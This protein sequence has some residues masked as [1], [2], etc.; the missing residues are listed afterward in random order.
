MLQVSQNCLSLA[1]TWEYAVSLNQAEEAGVEFRVL[2][3]LEVI[4]PNAAPIDLPSVSQRRLVC[5]LLIRGTMVS[6]DNLAHHLEVSPGA[7]RTTVS[8]LRRLL[9]PATLVSAPPGYQL[10]AEALDAREFEDCLAGAAAE[11]ECATPPR[12]YLEKGISLWR[13]DAYAE[14]AHEPWASAESSRLAE[15]RAGAIEDLAELLFER[16]EQSAAIA[17]LEAHIADYPFRDRPRGLLMR[18]LADAGRRVDALRAFQD[19]RRFLIGEVGTEPSPE[20]FSLDRAIARHDAVGDLTELPLPAR[21]VATSESPFAFFGRSDELKALEDL[22][23]RAITEHRLGVVLISGEPGVGKTSLVAQA[24][25]PVHEGGATVLYGGA[26]EG[27]AI[28]YKPWVEALT[29]LVRRLPDEVL[30]RFTG[31]NG[32]TLARLIPDLARRLGEQPPAPAAESDAERFMVMDSVVRFL[33]AASIETPLLVVLDDLHWAD[34]ASLQL[35]GQLAHSSMPMAVTVVGTFRHGDL[36][37]S[38]PLT[39]LLARLHREPTVERLALVGLEDF[40]IIGLMEAAAGHALPDEGVELAQALR[41]ETGGNP[42]FVVEM[43][44]HL[45]REGIFVQENDGAWRLTVELDEVGLPTS[46]REVVAQRVATLGAETERAL[47]MASVIGRDFDLSVLAAVLGHDELELSDLLEGATTA[48]LLLTLAG[49]AERY[50]FVHVLIQHTLY[51]DLSA[52]RRRRAHLQVAELLEDTGT[53][54]AER[55]AALA[56]HWLAATR[57]ADVT[58]AVYYARRAGQAALTAYAPDDAVAWFSQALEVLDRHGASEAE[59]GRILVQLSVA[60]NAAGLPGHRQTLLEAAEIAQRL[61]DADLL[62]AAALGGRRGF[63]GMTETDL[64]RAAL[65]QAALSALGQKDPGQRALLLGSLAE[66]T[67]SRDWRRR[68]ALADEA[69]SLGGELDDAAKLDVVLSC[70]QFRAQ[71]ERSAERLAQTAWACDTADRL[72]D[73]ILRHWARYHRIHACMEVGDLTE[74]DQRIEEIGPLVERT[75]LP[76][77]RWQLLLI[78]TWRAIVAGDLV[79]GERLNDEAVVVASDIGAPEAL[80]VWGA[81]LFDLRVQQGRVEELIDAFAQTAAENPAIPVLRVALAAGYCLVGRTDEAS[82]LVD[83]DVSTGFTEMPRDL[84][85]LTAMVWAQESAVVLRHQEAAAILYDLLH[86]FGDLVV[87]NNGTCYGSV[88]RSLGRLAHFL[89]QPEAAQAHFRTALSINERLKAPY[90]IAQTQLDHADLFR[91]LGKPDEAARL[92]D[93][94]RETAT[95]FGF[96]ALERRATRFSA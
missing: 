15:L 4:G 57:Q 90:W 2:G 81:V 29:P 48:G 13:G 55:L 68:R 61:G 49:D 80:G 26:D 27:L 38:H 91:D 46:V 84:T 44:R 24:A 94:A 47:S 36:S 70:Y 54:D 6:A 37:R 45:A 95:A 50:R 7:L 92:V 74:V 63:G 60:Q 86:P 51:Q 62:M 72:G 30:R 82:P 66:V 17:T 88:A 39:P 76:Y 23:K 19:Y 21:L 59:R 93:H 35:L 41:R 43:L 12:R 9:G 25:R 58:K 40:E 78:R 83:Q 53:N 64:E 65:F 96:A 22:H 31:N 69:L 10:R 28:P 14:F 32:L 85:W 56:R 89:E 3:A 42:F 77:C 16:G 52:T 75:G 87:F 73:P 34:A 20:L 18:A 67:D 11:V 5:F 1:L 33:T 79:T 71:P 8:R